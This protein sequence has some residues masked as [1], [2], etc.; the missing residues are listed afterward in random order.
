[1]S[2]ENMIKTLLIIAVIL[3]VVSCG[4]DAPSADPLKNKGIGPIKSVELRT[5]D[6][7]MA[8]KGERVFKSVCA[9]CHRLDSDYIGPKL[10]GIT[11]RRTPEWIMN[12]VL[13]TEEMLRK[14]PIAKELKKKHASTMAVG[15]L[16]EKDARNLLEFLRTQE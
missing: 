8:S 10:R 11:T 9:T 15:G 13:N 1:M 3:S 14:D 2:K 16:D 7:E 12:M 5:V 4:G 6:P